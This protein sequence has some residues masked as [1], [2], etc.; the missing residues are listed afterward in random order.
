MIKTDLTDD[1]SLVM[2]PEVRIPPRSVLA[3]LKPMGLGTPL[4]ESLASY[5]LTLAHV[6]HVSPKNLA[7]GIVIP[8]LAEKGL[9]YK[10]VSKLWKLSSFNGV[11]DVPEYWAK[12][13]S[14]LTGQ[15]DLIDLTLVPL[16]SCLSILRLM[17]DRKKWCPLCLSETAKSGR[18]YGQLLWEIE[19]PQ[20][21]PKHGIKLV[22]QCTCN[23][24]APMSPLNVKYL[25]WICESCGRSIA[26]DNNG[27][28]EHASSDE[29]KRARIVADLLGD[30]EKVKNRISGAEGISVFL[31]NAVRHLTGRNAALFGELIGIKRNTLHGWIHGKSIPPFPQLVDIAMMCECSIADVILG[32]Q[33]IFQRPRR[34][35]IPCPSPRRPFRTTRTQKIDKDSIRHQLEALSKQGPPIS[36]A[37]AAKK[38]GLTDRTLFNHFGDITKEMT[39]R[40]QAYRREKGMRKFKNRCHLYRQSAEN[41]IQRGIRPIRRLVA[42]DIRGRGTVGVREDRS[43]CSRICREAIEAFSG[44]NT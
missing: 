13:L 21:C 8:R 41:L 3:S 23:R 33:N 30:I 27:L 43:A 7:R 28:L 14:G 36:V 19:H 32:E 6:H 35:A 25:P 34:L 4:R 10:D 24:R 44:R 9:L 2:N 15:K 42:L 18:A 17:S 29:I 26:C 37:E 39:R 5:Y 40:V 1:Y 38:I 22:T 12:Q 20:A 16:R 11:G 31:I